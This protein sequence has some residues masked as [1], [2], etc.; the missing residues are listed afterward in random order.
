[1]TTVA[2][3]GYLTE[4]GLDSHQL[5]ARDETKKTNAVELWKS[6]VDATK[7]ALVL[8]TSDEIEGYV[9]SVVKDYFRTT[10][11][12]SL[13]LDSKF[14]DHGL[15]SLDAIEFVIR[16]EDE[17]GYVIDAENLEKFKKPR[18]FVNFIKHLEAYKTEFNKLP[19]E[20]NKYH[21]NF[22]EAFPGLPGMKH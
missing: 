20:G 14:A 1:M 13:T 5:A 18:H 21:F 19:H 22:A 17:L 2:C 4:L 9:L 7:N 8:K 3:R 16:I 11:K 15:D 10:K 6:Q 12:A